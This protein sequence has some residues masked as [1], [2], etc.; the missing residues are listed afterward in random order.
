ML[1]QQQCV[2]LE[3]T[4]QHIKELGDED[5]RKLV[6]LLCEAELRRNGH[7]VSAVSAGGNQTA[8]DGGT[9]VRVE[10]RS[11][12]TKGLDF[13]PN[14]NTVFQVK[15]ED[16]PSSKVTKEMKPGGKL[17]ESIKKLIPVNGAY[18]IVAS[19]GTTT[20]FFLEEREKA[21]R[22]A[23][24]RQKHASQ[25]TLK[26]YDRDKLATWVRQYPGVE[27]WVRDRIN[28]R[29]QGWMPF[30]D[31]AGGRPGDRYLKDD[32]ARLE[33]RTPEG[34]KKLRV[35]DGADLIRDKLRSPG[36]VLRL[37][38]LSG[39]GKTR[40]AQALFESGLGSSEP[41][42]QDLVRYTDLG[43]SPVPNALDMLTYLG[44][45][46][47][48][49]ILV[50]DNCNPSTHNRLAQAA[51]QFSKHVSL[52]TVE[53]DVVE[54]D[55][56]EATEV[57]EL[58]PASDTVLQSILRRNAQHL[59]DADVHLITSISGGNARIALA[60]A[61]T[62]LVGES[63]ASL[64]DSD[65]FDRL[66]HQ[67]QQPDPALL[68]AAEVCSL[69]YAFDA[70]STGPDS[71]LHALAKLAAML[72]QDLYRHV[73]SLRS[74]ELV[75]GR[76]VQRAVLPPALA[77]RLAKRA[78]RSI[79]RA[80][81]LQ[82]LEGKP[83]LLASFTRRLEYLH[84]SQEAQAIARDWLRDDSRLGNF[85]SLDDP[86]RLRLRRIAPLAEEQVLHGLERW[87]SKDSRE[88]FLAGQKDALSDWS[89][90]ARALAFDANLFERAALVVLQSA[91]LQTDGTLECKSA[92]CELFRMGLSGTLATQ[93]QRKRFLEAAL[94]SESPVRRELAR[95]AA[96]AMLDFAYISSS[97]DFAFGARPN[98]FGWHPETL[99][100][101]E[102]WLKSAL[103]LTRSVARSSPEGVQAVRESLQTNFRDL[104]RCPA[105]HG[106]VEQLM[107]ELATGG[108][109]SAGWVA[110]RGALR[111]DGPDMSPDERNRLRI[112]ADSLKP[113]GLAQEILAY[114]GSATAYSDIPDA[115][116]ETDEE[117]SSNPMAAWE[118]A[119]E[120][121]RALGKE[122]SRQLD[123]LSQVLPRLHCTGDLRVGAWA[124]GL[125]S[126][127]PDPVHSW[128]LL[129]QTFEQ[130]GE[131][132][133][134]AVLQGFLRGL[135][136]RDRAAADQILDSLVDNALL[137]AHFARLIDVP[138][139]DDDA[140][141]LLRGMHKGAAP[142]S[143]FK[144]RT[145]DSFG[146]RGLSL[147]KYCKLAEALS[148]LPGGIEAAI[149]GLV[150]EMHGLRAKDLQVPPEQLELGRRLLQR[151]ELDAKDHNFI[152]RITEL[153]KRCVPGPQGE[154]TATGLALKLA[155]AMDARPS[156]GH[157]YGELA[158]IVCQHHPRASLEILLDK[159]TPARMRALSGRQ[160]YRK[161]PLLELAPADAVIEWVADAP[162]ERAPLV[163]QLIAFVSRSAAKNASS[164]L[165]VTNSSAAQPTELATKLMAIAPDKRPVLDALARNFHLLDSPTALSGTLAP[166]LEV[167]EGMLD[168]EHPVIAGWAEE[169][170]GVLR[171][172]IESE[173]VLESREEERFE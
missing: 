42:N 44:S 133:E 27:L 53:Y 78:L 11:D 54:D 50:V 95:S 41:L 121:A 71:E 5:L 167:L 153:A 139:D 136:D 116:D 119:S 4:G 125:A 43:N 74:R 97:H 80:T 132:R 173:R 109:W 33:T 172:R 115:M 111:Y 145:A 159:A 57:F 35:S 91:E 2:M 13:I 31:W 137:E 61:R 123:V 83:R 96:V 155:A 56:P 60:L 66:F 112:L 3:L 10:L 171:R 6:F 90:L 127:S 72:D 105:V 166:Y 12:S 79:P 163:A 141:R 142:A 146:P 126:E 63:L 99:E 161:G 89:A 135:R 100:E 70:E 98:A 129:V 156:Y 147:A 117:A 82:V 138:L 124:E 134:V 81:L 51:Q 144:L 30:G 65:I 58:S 84:D 160:L 113:K 151:F 24:S 76:G 92:F 165:E 39:T 108:D 169:S 36:G 55:T 118:R 32:T 22:Q 86:E 75:Q 102:A 64:N 107:S 77:N 128:T 48:R 87:L 149:D 143:T 62:V 103:S 26:F 37:I 88:Q 17:R 38:G 122:A 106:E 45:H 40:L 93:E 152:T 148:H 68:R 164:L 140:A 21:M 34:R 9:D 15:C 114:A 170:I 110:A 101:N 120:K 25:L 1:H 52:L 18:V 28:A 73:D 49:A 67:Q 47:L 157:Y 131:G 154:P 158:R 23:V 168:S 150:H 7:P 130:A 162:Q 59:V 85:S 20:Q 16:I 69:V 19:K 29:L 104:W 46:E 14:A 8:K 94:K